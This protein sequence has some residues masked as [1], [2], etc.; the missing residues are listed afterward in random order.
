MP[1]IEIDADAYATLERLMADMGYGANTIVLT[2]LMGLERELKAVPARRGRPPKDEAQR[3]PRPVRPKR[4]SNGPHYL[5]VKACKPIYGNVFT[6]SL[7][8]EID[9]E[10]DVTVAI[11][12][13]GWGELMKDLE[14]AGTDLSEGL[15]G[16]TVP[17]VCYQGKPVKT[18]N[19]T[20]LKR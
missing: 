6:G 7:T 4:L 13:L 11:D 5:T 2:A 12:T 8:L 14:N 19:G 16:K 17:L 20:L 10:N 15:V 9:T 18:L 3:L 1:L